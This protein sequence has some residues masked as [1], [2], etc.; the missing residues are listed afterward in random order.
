MLFNQ[1]VIN[2]YD[3]VV[4][5]CH[6]E[7]TTIARAQPLTEKQIVKNFVD[8]GGRVFGSHFSFSY[9]RGV[10]G[11]TDAKNFQPSP[12]PLLAEWDGSSDAPFSIDISFAKGNAFADWLVTAGASTT[13]GQIV[14]ESV[15]GVAMSLTPGYNSQ[16]WITTSGGIP[17]F[18]VPMPVEKASTPT[19][20]CGRF[21]DTGLHVRSGASGNP[22]PSGCS[23]DA[24]LPQEK[25]WEFLIFELGACAIPDSMMPMPPPVP[26]PG[27]VNMPPG[28]VTQPPAPP[29]PPPPPPPPMVD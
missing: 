26:P 11:T 17:Y 13:R 2:K 21:V 22:F 29:P 8:A 12:W 7:S 15:E 23:T 6:G 3:M 27:A 28:P 24:M 14:L 9:F 20:Q 5:S 1:T 18:S 4:F 25:A 19:E 10:P 16:R